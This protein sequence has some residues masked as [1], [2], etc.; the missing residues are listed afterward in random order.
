MFKLLPGYSSSFHNFSPNNS[1][2]VC[3]CG[4]ALRMNLLTEISS[5]PLRRRALFQAILTSKICDPPEAEPHPLL[6][7]PVHRVGLVCPMHTMSSCLALFISTFHVAHLCSGRE[8]FLNG[9]WRVDISDC[10][11]LSQRSTPAPG[12]AMIQE[13]QIFWWLNAWF[14]INSPVAGSPH[15]ASW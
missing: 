6:S 8:H 1:L 14:W 4:Y 12:E 9:A 10:C 13:S 2:F 5:K 15:P 7:W 11:L 3:V